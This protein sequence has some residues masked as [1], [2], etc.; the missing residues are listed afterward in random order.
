LNS[1]LSQSA[2]QFLDE[3]IPSLLHLEVLLVLRRDPDQWSSAAA[4]ASQLGIAPASVERV[5]EELGA[6]N[7][8]DVRIA[9]NLVYRFAPLD[10]TVLPVLT[11]L[12]EA[13]YADRQGL[14]SI[15]ASRRRSSLA[16]RHFADAFRLRG[17]E[18]D[19]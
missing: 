10:E 7:L 17:P 9:S 12:A 15:L 19:G 16:A 11:E 18:S 8:V 13:R 14:E 6:R 3:K 5:L 4:V 2:R 1:S